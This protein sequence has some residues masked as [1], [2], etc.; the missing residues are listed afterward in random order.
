MFNGEELPSDLSFFIR[1]LGGTLLQK[2]GYTEF[3]R[4]LR[5]N[6]L[7]LVRKKKTVEIAI[8]FLRKIKTLAEQQNDNEVVKQV[9]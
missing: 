8:A 1:G 3:C 5:K 2:I 9:S 4:S 6:K 7:S